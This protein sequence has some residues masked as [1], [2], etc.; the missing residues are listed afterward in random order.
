M[1]AL[2]FYQMNIDF[3]LNGKIQKILKLSN[4]YSWIVLYLQLLSI[5]VRKNGYIYWQVEYVTIVEQL[6]EELYPLGAN[7][8]AMDIDNALRFFIEL[9][10][11]KIVEI[12]DEQNTEV[13]TNDIK[14]A[15]LLTQFYNLTSQ[16]G[17]KLL[18]D[19]PEAIRQ[20]QYREKKK[21]QEEKP[22]AALRQEKYRLNKHLQTIQL[23]KKE[24][25]KIILGDDN[26][27]DIA[28]Q[29]HMR[30]T[31]LTKLWNANLLKERRIKNG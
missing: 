17:I 10:L 3:W 13:V 27:S 31:T 23:F 1:I 30:P 25:P 14:G 18:S 6:E 26:I 11:V 16:T 28:S 21:K 19:R 4:G 20:R 8:S 24:N 22:T 9:K 7:F 2:K 15:L 29:L 5:A 12:S